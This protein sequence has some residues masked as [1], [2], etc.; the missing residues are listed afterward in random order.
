MLPGVTVVVSP[1]LALINDQV[2]YLLTKSISASALNSNTPTSEKAAILADLERSDPATKLLYLT[3]ESL[4]TDT[5]RLLLSDLNRRGL[6]SLV[7]VDEAHCISSWGHD[8]RPSFRRLGSLRDFVKSRPLTVMALTATAQPKVQ[9]D[10]ITSLKLQSPFIARLTTFR[11]NLYLEVKYKLALLGQPEMAMVTHV[12]QLHTKYPTDAGIV[13][14][15][16]KEDCE[17]FAAMLR[18]SGVSSAAYHGGLKPDQRIAVQADWTSGKTAVVVATVAFGMGVDKSNVRYVVHWTLSKSLEAYYQEAGRAG[19]D[20][21]QSHC[22]LFYSRSDLSTLKYFE[23]K[24]QNK[25]SKA[26]SKPQSHV[27]AVKGYSEQIKCRHQTIAKY[28]GDN[29]PPCQ[30]QCDVCVTPDAVSNALR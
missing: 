3:P 27:D 18:A 20:G 12:S 8:F 24:Q 1:L 26:A 2:Q 16:K 28:F 19:R 22:C 15:L 6:F 17:E 14:T 25:P 5:M 21:L 9:E 23:E 30:R 13:Y 11:K 7:A 10:I 4:A 29:I